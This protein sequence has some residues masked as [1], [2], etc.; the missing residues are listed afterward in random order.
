MSVAEDL[1]TAG[2]VT[3]P[4]TDNTV[5]PEDL[6]PAE[7]LAALADL[8]EMGEDAAALL[9]G[10]RDGDIEPTRGD[11]ESTDHPPIH[12]TDEL[13]DL[14]ELSEAEAEIYELVVRRFLATV[15]DPAEWA[16]LRVV[17]DAD[18]ASL[19]ANGRRLLSPGYHDVYP[20]VSSSEEHLPEVAEGDDLAIEDVR[21]AAKQ[22][23]PPRRYSQSRLVEIMKEK[24]VGT[25]S[26][27][28]HTLEKLYDRG[29]VSGDPPQPTKLAM[30]V[31]D[32]AEEYAQQIVTEDM[33][34]QLERDMTAIA[35]GEATLEDVTEES[36]EMLRAVF[37]DLSENH[38]AVGEL[39]QESLK[40]DAS[41]G[42]CPDCGERLLVRRSRSGSAFVGCDGYPD[43]EF[44]LPLPD[45]GE[46]EITD[47]VCTEHGLNEVRMLDGRNSYT[48]G[49]PL[50]QAE[51]AGDGPVVGTCP[52]CG[53]EHGGRLRVK[54]LRNGSR[55]VG[56]AR[57]PDCEYSLPLPRR[58]ELTVTD[59]RCGE[60]GLREIVIDA[61]SDEP[62]ELGC[63]VCNFREYRARQAEQGGNLDLAAVE[64]VDEETQK[65]LA[66][67]DVT[68]VADLVAADPAALAERMDV[69]EERVRVLRRA[70]IAAVE[71]LDE[72]GDDDEDED[73]DEVGVDPASDADAESGAEA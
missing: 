24:G 5:Y 42:E 61:D 69:G 8:P 35:E 1:Y 73:G 11:T 70:A 3:Y 23:Q 26:T 37:E 49:C 16:D 32:A 39:L 45:R 46:P 2:Y 41:L 54:R 21:L 12:P 50:C 52:D 29:Y 56:C 58:G 34:Q 38:E 28:H 57:Y 13:P 9:E 31:V 53:R 43:C 66:D 36:R 48:H 7:L 64:G 19:K 30:A 72:D 33:T 4:R 44:T 68:S 27:R 71:G 17:V 15:A 59:D 47:E 60:H 18:G 22:T 51:D 65:R 67:A 63:P 55:L 10:E 6:E 62:W 25:K 14:D 40:E 20:Y